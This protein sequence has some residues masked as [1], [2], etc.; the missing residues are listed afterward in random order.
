MLLKT[1]FTALLCTLSICNG[2]NFDEVFLEEQVVLGQILENQETC[3]RF[4]DGDRI[5]LN[6]PQIEPSSAGLFL[7]L[8]DQG[9][10]IHLPQLCSDSAGCFIHATKMAGGETHVYKQCPGCGRASAFYCKNPDCPLKKK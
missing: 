2:E 10:S 3:V 4:F 1:V 9:E 7:I 8:N 5:Y 6:E